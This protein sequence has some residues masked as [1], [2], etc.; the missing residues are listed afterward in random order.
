MVENLT[1]V[2][3]TFFLIFFPS[4]FI[5]QGSLYTFNIHVSCFTELN[6]FN[7]CKIRGFTRWVCSEFECW[8]Q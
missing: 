4:I 6:C 1:W 2:Y 7:P 8:C 5:A 3:V